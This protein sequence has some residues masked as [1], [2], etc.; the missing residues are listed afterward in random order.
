MLAGLTI[1][2]LARRTLR[3]IREENATGRAAELAYYFTLALFPM[4]IFLL[5]LISFIAGAD[6]I[7]LG[8]LA[9]VMPPDAMRVVKSWVDSVFAY[10]SGRLLSF[11]LILS[12]W[13]G[14]NGIGALMDA[15]N[16]AYAVEEGRP[17]WKAQLLALGL[18]VA[19][20]LLVMGGALI[21]T[22]GEKPAWWI[23]ERLRLGEIFG[24]LWLTFTYVIGLT[25]LALGMGIIYY[26]APN[27]QQRCHSIVPG[28]VFAIVAFLIVSYAFTLYLRF[29]PSYD[30]TYG[31][32]GAFIV[33]MVWLYLTGLIMCVGGEINAEIQSAVGEKIVEKEKAESQAA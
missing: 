10:R 13:F 6:E 5:S 11:G 27:V 25:M 26:M 4:L 33:L 32:L 18:T 14:S 12:V 30:I 15:L 20:C 23:A 16:R 2:E 29:A 19:L 31:S 28:C 21:V 22:V 24:L 3:N 9:T 8:W 1:K 17:F 7:I